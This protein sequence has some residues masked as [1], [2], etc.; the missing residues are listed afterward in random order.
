MPRDGP[1]LGP[2]RVWLDH[3]SLGRAPS[4]HRLRS[5]RSDVVRRLHRYY[6]P[7]RSP[8]PSP[9]FTG[10]GTGQTTYA[11]VV[12]PNVPQTDNSSAVPQSATLSEFYT[13][14]IY[15][16]TPG[17]HVYSFGEANYSGPPLQVAV[18]FQNSI[19]TTVRG[20]RYI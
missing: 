5:R 16:L 12:P 20:G 9:C 2:G 3:V 6:G 7:V 11:G 4:L 14:N 19:A 18:E 15:S 10:P 17:L 8:L 1:A 13:L